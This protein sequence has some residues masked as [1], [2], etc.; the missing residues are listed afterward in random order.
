MACEYPQVGVR[1]AVLSS[2]TA[3][4]PPRA[5]ERVPDDIHIHERTLRLLPAGAASRAL[6]AT[7]LHGA[8]RA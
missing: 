3:E 2:G 8:L 1:T 4:H 7:W 6:A 5:G